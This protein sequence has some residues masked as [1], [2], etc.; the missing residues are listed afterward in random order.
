LLFSSLNFFYFFIVYLLVWFLTPKKFK[1]TI[2]VLFSL[3]FY[4]YW[5]YYYSLFPVVLTLLA[6][7][8]TF[9]IN[10]S[11][12]YINRITLFLS[13]FLV[14]VP[15]IYFKYF[16]FIFN[17]NTVNLSL[18]LGISFIT[19]T[20]ISYIIDVSKKRYPIEKN[21]NILLGYILFFPQLIAGPILRPSE[22]IPQL[23]NLPIVT[24][25]MRILAITIFTIGLAKK[26]IFADQ[27]APYV[28]S[29][30]ASPT[31]AL[32]HEWLIAIYGFSVQIYCDFSGYSDMAIGLALFFGIKLPINFDRPYLATSVPDIWRKW[33]ITLSTWFRDYIYFPIAGR[34]TNMKLH[35]FA[36]L[37]TMTVCGIWHGAG[38]NFILW[39]F[40]NG[41]LIAITN[42]LRIKRIKIP[43]PTALKIFLTFHWWIFSTILFRS[44]D[45]SNA[46]DVCAQGINW[47][48]FNIF[49]L[50]EY[51]FPLLLIA[52]FFISHYFDQFSRVEKITNQINK[53]Y[54]FLFLFMI[55][56][57]AIVLGSS[58]EGSEKF[59][60][61]DF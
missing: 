49:A 60:Y 51:I 21:F 53:K 18:P 5:N 36:A 45:L 50:K 1:I 24:N 2:I 35:F 7:F 43:F 9:Y 26:L 59:I 20:L 11:T 17:T 28:D 52:I 42:L 4:G 44:T 33:H 6:Y 27:L 23:K 14:S 56:I 40:L 12:I 19:F 46:M 54:L 15:L 57:I 58:S 38:W 16:N 55:W 31:T 13:I 47:T 30:Y 29:V 37:F 39:G 3:F 34:K 25:K 48:T 32:Y 8:F 61:F 22:L 41:L 10:T